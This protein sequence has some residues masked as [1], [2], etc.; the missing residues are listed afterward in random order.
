VQQQTSS[1]VRLLPLT[2]LVL[3]MLL[4]RSVCIVGWPA[5]VLPPSPV[6]MPLCTWASLLTGRAPAVPLVLSDPLMDVQ[7]GARECPML[8]IFTLWTEEGQPQA[9]HAVSVGHSV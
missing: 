3:G 7:A 5:V 2:Q 1:L 4:T 8:C 6:G 9:G